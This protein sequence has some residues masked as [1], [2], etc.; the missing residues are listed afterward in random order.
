MYYAKIDFIFP[1]T[2]TLDILTE[3]VIYG[4]LRV[5]L[6]SRRQNQEVHAII[7]DIIKEN[8]QTLLMI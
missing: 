4:I 3:D 7:K 8:F 5:F 2:D 6:V 1:N